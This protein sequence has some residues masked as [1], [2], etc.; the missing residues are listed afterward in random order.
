M[1]A[2]ALVVYRHDLQEWNGE[3]VAPSGQMQKMRVFVNP[4]DAKKYCTLLKAELLMELLEDDDDD[5]YNENVNSIYGPICE[6]KGKVGSEQDRI[7]NAMMTHL[8]RKPSTPYTQDDRN[9][10]I[11]FL[12]THWLPAMENIVD[13]FSSFD[14]SIGERMIDFRIESCAFIA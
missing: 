14:A 6:L 3:S 5:H 4:E 7:Y 11:Q 12:A 10:W 2:Q 13:H 8:H 1:A 9:T